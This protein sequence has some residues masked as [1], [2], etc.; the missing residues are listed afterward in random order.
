MI[1]SSGQAL[2]WAYQLSHIRIMEAA[3]LLI[4]FREDRATGVAKTAIAAR[5]AEITE[6][7][8]T[9]RRVLSPA[10]SLREGRGFYPGRHSTCGNNVDGNL[11][12]IRRA[13]P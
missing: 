5:H 7:P 11:R 9:L 13:L 8:A 4:D 6:R 12:W 2:A 1:A 3:E 10:F